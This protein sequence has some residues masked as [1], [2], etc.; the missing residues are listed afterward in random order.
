MRLSK[1]FGKTLREV[2]ADAETVSHQL[3]LKAGMV[4][5]V[6]A[7]VYS[8]LPLAWRSLRKIEQIIREEMNAAGGQELSMPVLQPLEI[9]EESGRDFAFGKGLFTLKDRRDRRLVL[10]PTHE[11]VITDLARRNVRSYRDLPLMLYQIQTKF[12]DEP[13]PRGGLVRVREFTMKDCY[14]FDIDEE[15]LELSYQKMKEAYRNIYARCSLEAVVVEADSG[16]IGGKDS[17]E[18]MVIAETGE[19]EVIYCGDCDYSANVERAECAKSHLEEEA[20]LP[21]EEVAT[22]G[23]RTIEEVANFLGVT[24]DRTLKAVFYSADGELIFITIR[25]DLEVNEVKLRNALKCSELRLASDEE[26]KEAGLVA[27]SASAVGL[28]GIKIVADDSINLGQNFVVGANKPDAHIKNTNYRRDFKVDIIT[29]IAQAEAGHRCPRC[30]GEL[31]STRGI[32]VGHIFKLGT[33]FSQKQAAFY[34]D[35]DGNQ[36]PMVM[37]CYGIGLGRLLAAAIEQNHDEDGIIWPVP[38]APYH[39][40]LCAL[41]VDDQQVVSVSEKLYTELEENGIEVLIDDRNESAGVKFN[42][43]DLLGMPVRLVVSKRALKSNSAELK[44]RRDR[45]SELVP[46]DEVADRLKELLG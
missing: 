36:K 30:G 16:A 4:Q 29:D 19:D 37:G 3:L 5:Q 24:R 14:S 11:E 43:A 27:G 25:G 9:W 15:A 13:R 39:V 38:I 28:K 18:F 31:R 2:P 10:G 21:M 40:Y 23:A 26:V 8:Y 35:R 34:L 6:A 46:L 17:H 42:D 12:R 20:L 33:I 22:P 1:M 7:G 44:M 32:E 45:E 41:G